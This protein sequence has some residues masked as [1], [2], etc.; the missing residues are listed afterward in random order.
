[1]RIVRQ[2][3]HDITS[4]YKVNLS[5]LRHWWKGSTLHGIAAKHRFGLAAT[6]YIY[7]MLQHDV[8]TLIVDRTVWIVRT[9][10]GITL[11]VSS[12]RTTSTK[13]R[14]HT[15]ANDN[16][17]LGASSIAHF[18]LTNP[19]WCSPVASPPAPAKSSKHCRG[20]CCASK[21]SCSRSTSSRSAWHSWQQRKSLRRKGRKWEVFVG[22]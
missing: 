14:S 20:P 22:G 17:A 8:C 15:Y 3:Y 19:D 16:A 10:H 12:H 11:F 5:R 18:V 1:M 9:R 7:Y 21:A 13:S 4:R 2:Q 6:V